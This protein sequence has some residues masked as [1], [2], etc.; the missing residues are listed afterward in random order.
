MTSVLFADLVGFT[1]F[2]EA[3]DQ[4]E[5]RELLSRYFDEARLVIGRYGGLIEKFIGDAVMAVWGV[6]TAHDDDAERAVRAGLE[7]VNAISA[8]GEDVGTP[9][10][11]VRVGIF[12]GEVA[13]TVGAENQG[14]VAGDAV[15]TAARIQSTAQPGHVWVDETTRL[16]TTSAISYVDEGSH[17]LKG[18]SE[19]LPLWSARAVFAALGG[20]QRA[21]GL[22]APL[23]GRDRELRVLKAIFHGV[24]E[25][26]TPGLVV[27][28]GEPG[29]GKTRLGWELEKYIDGLTGTVRWHRGRCIAYG[30]GVAYYALAEAIRGRLRAALADPGDAE[31]TARL[32]EAGLDAYVPIEEERDW[33]RPR[34]GVLL[35][36]G[37]GATLPR[38]D[39]FSAW[40]TFLRRVGDA[41]YPVTLMIDDAHDADEGLLQFLEHLIGLDGFA[42]CVVLLTR[43]GLLER[44]PTLAT[45]RRASIIHLAPLT[46]RDMATMLDGLVAGVPE[47]VRDGLVRRAEGVPLFAVETVRSLIDR[48][49]VVPRGGQYVLADPAA[50]DLDTI[51]A[52]ASLQALVAARLDTLSPELRRIVVQGSVLGGSFHPEEIAHLCSDV[53]DLPAAL[54]G[55]VRLQILS[56]ETSRLS[57]EYG[58][59]KFVQ[60]VVR[61][62]AYATMSRRDRKAS[63][64]SVARLLEGSDDAGGDLAPIIAQHYVDALDAVPTDPDASELA[65]R[66]IHHLREAAARARALGS[67]AE[68]G[69]HL[70]IALARA[71]DP[72]L[73]ASIEADLAWAQVDA[74]LFA[75]SIDH[76]RRATQ[77]FDGAGDEVRAGIAAAAHAAALTVGLGDNQASLD[78]A[79]PR[80]AALT[81]RADAVKARVL[82]ARAISTARQRL[83][84]DNTDVVE[85]RIRI[86]EQTGDHGELA[87]SY[88]ELSR[89]YTAAGATSLSRILLQAAADLARTSHQPVALARALSDLTAE[90]INDDLERSV[91][92][93][94]EAVEVAAKAGV[95]LWMSFGR[96]N[97]A[98]GLWSSGAVSELAS[99]PEMTDAEV[100]PVNG[101]C[102][103]AM[104]L[105]VATVTD[106]VSPSDAFELAVA[107]DDPV[108]RGWSLFLAGLQARREHSDQQAL[109]LVMDALRQ[110]YELYGPWDD[111]PHAWPVAADLALELGSDERCAELLGIAGEGGGERVPLALQAHRTHLEARLAARRGLDP[112]QVEELFRSAIRDYDA[113]GS[114]PFRARAEV[115][116]G[117]WLIAQ[118][119][120]DE[121]AEI[122]DRAAEVLSGIG[123]VA[124]VPASA[125]TS[126]PKF[127]DAGAARGSM[128]SQD[129]PASPGRQEWPR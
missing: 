17:A 127:D 38:E 111:L 58:Q 85:E 117:Q 64:V 7:L 8:L 63:H 121:G 101:A 96:L 40:A 128:F 6:P 21:D 59:F 97:L 80:W 51:G 48:D 39:L 129:V 16:L 76:A 103:R 43:P 1:T 99:F 116:L 79:E 65:E 71:E 77:I 33:L 113:W 108:D 66:A 11:T 106:T 124:W 42:C 104:Q 22:E 94:R 29:V 67:P 73:R 120:G 28:D 25:S 18:K 4:E 32:I 110:F 68:A 122:V 123:A 126:V 23:A 87:D 81:G 55:L 45:N 12:T 82:L 60:D 37:A 61:Q 109:D 114:I 93:G 125:A 3:R 83:S 27:V 57:S 19:P 115:D 50:L 53:E 44:H 15:N 102:W 36:L 34:L 118:G 47:D 84:L 9:G 14:M 26:A 69:A 92:F 54:A 2:S 24:E 72:L 30:E 88:T 13:V 95:R 74:G 75:E 112:S 70:G 107:S 119:R 20:A 56:Q 98:L 31:D 89:H 86:A 52:P 10:L 49:L 62:V 105:L 100:D 35:G 91:G 5:V 41:S 46:A 78:V 90:Y